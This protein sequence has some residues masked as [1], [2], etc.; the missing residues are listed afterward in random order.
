MPYPGSY[1]DKVV[2]I[3]GHL[4]GSLSLMVT[5]PCF[6]SGYSSLCVILIDLFFM[7]SGSE[8]SKA[9]ESRQVQCCKFFT[10]G[11]ISW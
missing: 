7:P 2:V 4:P 9:T 5:C 11:F 8:G 3:N 10:C 6:V 1:Y